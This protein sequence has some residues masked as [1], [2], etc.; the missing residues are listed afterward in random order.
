MHPL[1]W[2]EGLEVS[3]EDGGV[4]VEER[5]HGGEGHIE[6]TEQR[7]EPWIHLVPAT[8]HQ[9]GERDEMNRQ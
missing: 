9:P 7:H 2:L 5:V 3:S 1:T 6:D 8:M 4:D